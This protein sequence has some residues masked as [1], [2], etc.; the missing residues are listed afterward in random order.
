MN[1]HPASKPQFCHS[2]ECETETYV[3]TPEDMEDRGTRFAVTDALTGISRYRLHGA[4]I[5]ADVPL[6]SGCDAETVPVAVMVALA[7]AKRRAA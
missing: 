7:P 3:M 2:C 6:C 5:A 1:M 4:L